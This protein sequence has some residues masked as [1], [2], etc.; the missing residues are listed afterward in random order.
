M[1]RVLANDARPT[2]VETPT[3]PVDRAWVG[4]AVLVPG[5][6][7][8][9]ATMRTI[10]LAY[11]LR[12]GDLILATRSIPRLDT[13]TFSVPGA[14][15]LDHQW[16]AQL[17]LA[18][19]FRAGGWPTLK[20]LQAVLVALS[21]GLVFLACRGAGATHRWA[22]GLT[23]AGFTVASAA[24]ALRPQL[25]GLPLFA[26]SLWVLTTRH[27]H[28]GRLWALPGLAAVAANLHGSFTLFPLLV[29]LAWLE[30]RRGPD[31]RRLLL[32][33]AAT[34]LA[35]LLNPFGI[36]AWRYAYELSTN[37]IIRETITEWSAVSL[38]D[39]AGAVVLGSALAVAAFL[40]RRAEAI[41][42]T[43][44]LRLGVFLVLA[45]LA[46]RAVV[47][48][49]VVAPVVL[50]G[51]LPAPRTPASP[52]PRGSWAPA[53]ALL[54][55]LLMAVVVLLPWW[56]GAGFEAHLADAPPGITRAVAALP[57]GSRLFNHQPWGS[58]FILATPQHRVFVDSRIEIVPEPVWDDYGQVAF[59]GARWRE[60]LA[61]WR[62][63]AIVAKAD[64]ELIP[65][66]RADP[67]WRVLYEDEDGVVFVPAA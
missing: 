38:A 66:L 5:L 34:A 26:V 62:P 53:M 21:F 45:L 37:P 50:A 39:P 35:T 58:W 18:S 43:S 65:L 57:T 22:A 13:F 16:G 10:D 64:W 27:R 49:A 59:A 41:S 55:T 2:F 19:A 12:T 14:P 51:L 56:R 28:P 54:G 9:L 67:G 33:G 47:W 60:V 24:L 36:D 46:I 1:G 3:R 4:V 20:A 61:R 32:V 17:A 7:A 42:W 30:D 8:L 48:W 31:G 25:L 11:H 52:G 23:L 15:W 44:L 63:D 40:A 29:G 6:V